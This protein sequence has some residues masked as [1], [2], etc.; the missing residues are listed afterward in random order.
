[1]ATPDSDRLLAETLAFNPELERVLATLPPVHT[2]PPEETRRARRE[3][4]GVFP[5][6]A[7]LPGARTVEI[8]VRWVSSGC[9][10]FRSVRAAEPERSLRCC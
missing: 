5:A 10:S 4:R 6:P 3:G 7:F 2:L 9:G 8:D 1:M